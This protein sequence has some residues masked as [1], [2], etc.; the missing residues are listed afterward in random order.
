MAELY[1]AQWTML[2]SLRQLR[3]VRLVRRG[4]SPRLSESMSRN[5]SASPPWGQSR[6]QTPPP[7][8]SA[9]PQPNRRSAPL[10]QRVIRSSQSSS[11]TASG[12]LSRCASSC[13]WAAASPSSARLRV[14]MSLT[15]P[16]MATDPCP[17][18]TIAWP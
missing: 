1:Q 18:Q 16:S 10:V 11:I 6:S 12:E 4:L 7:I 13:R 2:P 5:D 8:A 3:C 17:S 15:N 9:A 14:V